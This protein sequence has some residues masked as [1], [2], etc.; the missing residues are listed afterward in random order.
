MAIVVCPLSRVG[1]VA[2]SRRPSRVVSLLDPHTPF[3]TAHEV[4]AERHL[5]IE[6]HDIIEPEPGS[7]IPSR[8]HVDQVLAFVSDWDREAPMLIHCYAGISRSTATAF[9]T[10][11]VHNPQTD[12]E[13]IAWALRRASATAHPNGRLVGLAD[14]ALGRGGRMSRAIAAIGRGSHS[15]YE[16][17]EDIQ[18]FELPSRFGEGA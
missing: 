15:W 10:A 18:P 17:T 14:A 2:A 7:V 4:P 16:L 11:C 9:I 1:S 3:P 13:E 8:S 6:V 12:E 5:K